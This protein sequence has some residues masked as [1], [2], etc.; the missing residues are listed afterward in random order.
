[1]TVLLGCSNWDDLYTG[2]VTAD[3]TVAFLRKLST[4]RMR[5]IG[6]GKEMFD[7]LHKPESMRR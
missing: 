3:A 2:G 4:W 5:R 6:I 7:V 1:M